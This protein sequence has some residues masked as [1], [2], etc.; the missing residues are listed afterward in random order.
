MIR[1]TRETVVPY[2][3]ERGLI[4]QGRTTRVGELGG[5]VSCVVLDVTQGAQR[6]VVKQALERLRVADEWLAPTSRAVT[7]ADALRLGAELTP[8]AVPR[9]LDS[10]PDNSVLAIE[11]APQDWRDWKQALLEGDADTDVAAWL[12]FVCATWH[13]GTLDDR[14]V[15]AAF[16][17]SEA[18]E[19]LRIDP[20][21]RTVSVRHPELRPAITA[22]IGR[23]EG[24]RCC[25]VHGDFSPKNVL[26]GTGGR[27]V[28]DF[29]VA[30]YGNPV[31]DVAFMLNH[32]FLKA[33]HRPT[34]TAGYA[35][36][37]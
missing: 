13:S 35:A 3:V 30:H 18:F 34:A 4:A 5:G 9:V 14:A 28:I 37:A 21:Y 8:G 15:E 24:G 25:L 1:L 33:I 32:L 29:E 27:W 17:H 2:L 7:E 26:V 22:A 11:R 6:I 20:Y 12:G 19:S 23:L 10:D 31:F 36:A 16:A